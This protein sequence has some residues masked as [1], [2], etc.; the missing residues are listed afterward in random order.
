MSTANVFSMALESYQ[1]LFPEIGRKIIHLPQHS[2]ETIAPVRAPSLDET[3]SSIYPLP[4]HSCLL[5]LCADGIPF[6]LDLRSKETGSL[7]VT[8]D[9]DSEKTRQLQVIVESAIR[10]SSPHELQVAVLTRNPEVW[11]AFRNVSNYSR[12]FYGLQGWYEQEASELI[13]RLVALGED[14]S[15]GRQRGAT[16]LLVID[17]LTGV[18]EADFEYQ[19]GLHQLLELGP[20]VQ[21]RPV[22]S[23]DSQACVQYPFWLNAFHTFL[24]GKITLS[25][26][27]LDLG[28][29]FPV[30]EKSDMGKADF[31]AYTGE[32]WMKY[33]LPTDELH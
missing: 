18:L 13:R 21:I 19:D 29:S 22:A 6:L 12:Y 1:R 14:R 2:P 20:A 3:L 32:S 11:S 30:D 23:L 31:H 24:I 15:N 27:D 8:G 25:S 5:G 4:P 28:F 17:D 26:K 7:L 16:I 10:S 9:P 33:T